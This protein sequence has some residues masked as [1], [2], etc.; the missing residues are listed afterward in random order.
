L[1][2]RSRGAVQ[3]R[4]TAIAAGAAGHNRDTDVATSVQGRYDRVVSAAV[5]LKAL[6]AGS[7]PPRWLLLFH[8]MPP[9][10]SYVRVKIWRRLQALGAVP[11]KNSVYA[12]P[13][14]DAAFEDFQWLLRELVSLGGEGSVCEARFVDGLDDSEIEALFNA[15]RDADY[16]AIAE[17]ARDLGKA[18]AGKALSKKQFAAHDARVSRLTKRLADTIALDFCDATGR[19]SAAGLVEDVSKKL[20]ERKGLHRSRSPGAPHEP[21]R[22]RTWVTRTGVHIDRIA[23][24]WLIRRFIDP[25]AQ[26]KFVPAKGYVPEK[27]ELRF[28]MFEAEFTHEGDLCTFEVLLRRQRIDDAALHAIAEIVHD[29]DLKEA[30]YARSE[31]AGVQHIV[32]GIAMSTREDEARIAMATPLFEGLYTHFGKG[33]PTTK[34]ASP[35]RMH[36]K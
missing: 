20:A 7:A 18:L 17:E 22:R 12:L 15:A 4:A 14:T 33:A 10:P 1:Y 11:V 9:K 35:R 24:A 16:A 19:Q 29:I 3:A 25:E 6:G 30:R 5:K 27:G 21:L 8:Q 31:T 23:S 34:G 26:F 36:K 28:D 32:N 13:R 2:L